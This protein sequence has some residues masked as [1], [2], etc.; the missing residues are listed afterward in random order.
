MRSLYETGYETGRTGTF[1]R[2]SVPAAPL[3][4]ASVVA[5]Q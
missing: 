1:W 5:A 2:K 3:V 4:K